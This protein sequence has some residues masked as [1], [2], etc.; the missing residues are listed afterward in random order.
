MGHDQLQ[1]AAFPGPQRFLIQIPVA[2]ENPPQPGTPMQMGPE[3]SVFG[4]LG[5]V[6]G[7]FPS[8][9]IV[10]QG[11]TGEEESTDDTN[12]LQHLMPM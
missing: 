11:H 3:S 4:A 2:F 10:A 5:Q 12:R 8:L 7:N 1:E 9:K 6:L